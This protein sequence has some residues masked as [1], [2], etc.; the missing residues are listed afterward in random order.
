M[1]KGVQREC[2]QKEG[3][4]ESEIEIYRESVRL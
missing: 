3:V 2:K 1:R 4:R